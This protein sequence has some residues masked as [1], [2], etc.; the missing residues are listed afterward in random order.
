MDPVQAKTNTYNYLFYP[1]IAFGAFLSFSILPWNES[2]PEWKW[3]NYH[4]LAMAFAFVPLS[5]IAVL[6]KKI[7][8]YENTKTHGILLSISTFSSF[9]GLYVIYSNKELRH[10]KHFQTLHGKLGLL[11]MGSYFALMLFGS[12]ALHPDWGMASTKGN[13]T[14]RLIHKWS[15]R[16][17]MALAWACVFTGYTTLKHDW[18]SQTAVA[19]PFLAFSYFILL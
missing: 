17:T 19:I 18:L 16:F 4:P 6:L 10:A 9:F 14:L 2:Y 7:G 8:G 15:G 12:F 1:L 13:A 11:V 3:F 5:S